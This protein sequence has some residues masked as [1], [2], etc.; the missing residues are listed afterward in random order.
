MLHENAVISMLTV[1]NRGLRIA[2]AS[3]CE[4]EIF[5]ARREMRKVAEIAKRSGFET[6]AELFS[7][8]V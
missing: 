8:A 2:L 7:N 4:F 1:A 5:H 6:H 3:G